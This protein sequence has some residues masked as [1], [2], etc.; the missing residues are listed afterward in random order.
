MK[1]IIKKIDNFIVLKEI[2]NIV[3]LL[4]N[5]EGMDQIYFK[6]LKENG[7]INPSFLGL[8]TKSELENILNVNPNLKENSKDLEKYLEKAKKKNHIVTLEYFN[9]KQKIWYLPTGSYNLNRI[10]SNKGLSSKKITLLYGKF[11]SGKSQIA[12][13][14]C[15]EA[16]QFFKEKL[17]KYTSLFIDTEGTFRPE[18]IQQM[19]QARNLPI[20]DVLKRIYVIQAQSISEFKLIF[21]KIERILKENNIKFLV[22]DSLTNY[23][24]LEIAQKEKATSLIINEFSQILRKISHWAITFN[25]PLLCTSQVSSTMNKFNF[26][27]VV[28]ILSTTLNSYIKEWILLGEDPQIT[29]LPE[30]T[31]RRFAHLVNSEINREEIIQFLIDSDGIKDFY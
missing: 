11:R 29:S 21:S 20:N 19:A 23:I 9:P 24:R 17:P 22:I 13:Q 28:P 5:L 2:I 18:R 6:G 14:C 10:L 7:W 25:I 12:H 26:F 3:S 1:L 15:V 8:L 4:K 30:N 31:G 27:D 16:Y